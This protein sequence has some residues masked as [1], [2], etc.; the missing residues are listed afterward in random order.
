MI[1]L[2][3]RYRPISA[4]KMTRPAAS[5]RERRGS[6][7]STGAMTPD[8]R[9]SEWRRGSR[10]RPHRRTASATVIK[11]IDRGPEEV[12]ELR[13]AQEQSQSRCAGRRAQSSV[14]RCQAAAM[15]APANPPKIEQHRNPREIPQRRAKEPAKCAEVRASA[16]SKSMVSRAGTCRQKL[17]GR[18]VQEGD[19]DRRGNEEVEA[20][21][22]DRGDEHAHG[23]GE[24]KAVRLAPDLGDGQAQRIGGL[25]LSSYVALS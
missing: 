23:H 14:V 8:Q 20:K 21:G 6:R 24:D 2:L 13:R 18:G 19:L 22:N 15:E 11:T 17:E 12:A 5:G 4:P 7:P 10:P 3:H 1:S 16:D 25:R 9:P